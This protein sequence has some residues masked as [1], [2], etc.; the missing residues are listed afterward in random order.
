MK[1]NFTKRMLPLLLVVVM[2]LGLI[3]LQASAAEE[4][5]NAPLLGAITDTSDEAYQNL[6][7]TKAGLKAIAALKGYPGA[8]AI[9]DG[10]F[11]ALFGTDTDRVQA[12][13]AKISQKLDEIKAQMADMT[14]Y[15][16]KKITIS[17]LKDTIEKSINN[18]TRKVPDY[19]SLNTTYLDRLEQL[20]EKKN[21]TQQ[22]KDKRVKDTRNFYLHIVNKEEV[23]GNK[24]H[25]AVQQLGDTIIKPDESTSWDVFTAFDKLVLYS[26]NWEHQGYAA[27]IAFQSH[28]MTLYT[29]LSVI[30]MSGLIVG[31]DDYDKQLS[32]LPAD[33]AKRDSLEAEQG[34]MEVRL[35]NLKK[36]IAK[37]DALAD[38]HPVNVRS[39]N[40][41]YYQVPGHELLLETW[42]IKRTVNPTYPKMPS[43][44]VTSYNIFRGVLCYG[45]IPAELRDKNNPGGY[46]PMPKDGVSAPYPTADWFISVYKDYGGTKNLYDIFFSEGEGGF[47]Y[48]HIPN[49]DIDPIPPFVTNDWWK[50]TD[51][52]ANKD[53]YFMQL[54]DKFGKPREDN[55]LGEVYLSGSAQDGM[56]KWNPNMMIGLVV[57]PQLKAGPPSGDEIKVSGM[58]ESY[59]APYSKDIRLYIE[60]KGELYTYEWQV[61]RDGHGFMPIDGANS[62]SYALGTV[63]DSMNGYQYRCR[64]IHHVLDGD[65]DT[66]TTEAVTLNLIKDSS[67]DN[68]QTGDNSPILLLSLLIVI[69]GAS[70][71]AIIA[72]GKKRRYRFLKR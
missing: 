10:A 27:R 68:P 67:T 48:L 6:N 58:A 71:I 47:D 22:E 14:E 72:V 56:K 5:N 49:L 44:W 16:D 55:N 23:N 37:I 18:Y 33:D 62:P 19:T 41:R 53:I 32:V 61:D 15:L 12:A 21:E 64:I 34:M 4:E 35:E 40:Q 39:A 8:G 13:L 1:R 50:F 26:Y 2:L 59:K 20:K 66:V 3:P 70:I 69:S 30:S 38:A 25:L 11:G 65:V 9:V 54:I 42:A 31:I 28:I 43:G 45:D 57:V 52:F 36:Q 46:L 63:D 60:D 29:S 24:F 51:P 17:K 7:N